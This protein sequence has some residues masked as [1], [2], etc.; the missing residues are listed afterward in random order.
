MVLSNQHSGQSIKLITLGCAKNVVDSEHL[1]GQLKS[2][3]FRICGENSNTAD[4]LIIN[5]CGFIADAKEESV[6][7]IL[8]A[9]KQ[10]LDRK[11]GKVL[12]MGC[13]SQRYREVLAQEIPEVDFFYGVNQFAELLSDLGANQKNLLYNE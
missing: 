8:L 10:K 12:V 2:S 9:V 5:T 7:T 1:L 4:I 11:V 13:L 6:N 3:G